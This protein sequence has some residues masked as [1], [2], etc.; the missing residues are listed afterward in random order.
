MCGNVNDGWE[1]LLF[2]LRRGLPKTGSRKEKMVIVGAGLAGLTAAKLLKDVGH[3]VIILEASDR[4][5]G[6]V[7]THRYHKA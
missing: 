7:Q 5:G 2:Y 4:V 3:D 1:E 6:R